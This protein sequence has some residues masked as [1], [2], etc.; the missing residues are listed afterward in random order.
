MSTSTRSISSFVELLPHNHRSPLLW[1][2]TDGAVKEQTVGLVTMLH[3]RTDRGLDEPWTVQLEAWLSE[4]NQRP[5]DINLAFECLAWCYAIPRLAK[6]V[7]ETLVWELIDKLG[8]LVGDA[9]VFSLDEQPLEQQLLSG[10]L[11]LAL[12]AQ[13]T[14]RRQIRVMQKGSQKALSCGLN[15]MLD[16]EGL[17][18]FHYVR[19]IRV[20]MASWTRSFLS[21]RV[22][23]AECFSQDA[24]LQ[25]EWLLRQ[26]L[27]LTRADGTQSLSSNTKST[28]WREMF[29]TALSEMGDEDDWQ[30]AG[31]VLP[32]REFSEKHSADQIRVPASE[33]S[34]WAKLSVLRRDW[35]RNSERLILGYADNRNISELEVGG[36]VIWSGVCNP[37]V[38]IDG[39][40]LPVVGNW[41]EVCWISDEDGDYIELENRLNDEWTVHR[42]IFLARQ[43]RFLYFADSLTGERAADIRYHLALPLANGVSWHPQAETREGILKDDAGRNRCQLFPLALTEWT[44]QTSTGYVEM[45]SEQLVVTQTAHSQRIYVPLFLDFDTRRMARERTWRQLT[46]AEELSPVTSDVAIGFRIHLGQQQWLI[47]RSLAPIASRSVLGQNL[48][49][50]LL[51][52]RF[53]RVD[54]TVQALVEIE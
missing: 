46:V 25:Y 27:R 40:T 51:I 33:N 22:I 32:G 35:S 20:L 38:T 7:S 45:N 19:W 9:A 23:K 36:K 34:E 30:I 17:P 6:R 2:V 43:D 12:S 15:E 49:A 31:T 14:D 28:S 41:E 53:D 16:G 26:I 44:D 5:C 54:G 13:M 42:Q 11:S 21:A 48:I 50:D 3:R 18:H 8:D 1:A 47:Y 4:V 52:G 24:Q 29:L 10:E 37:Q 39:R